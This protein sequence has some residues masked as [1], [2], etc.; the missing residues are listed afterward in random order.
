MV[1]AFDLIPTLRA[2]PKYQLSSSIL[3]V[4]DYMHQNHDWEA[5]GN[6]KLTLC[7]QILRRLQ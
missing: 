2:K 1:R 3:V 6:P 4:K 5:L 7:T